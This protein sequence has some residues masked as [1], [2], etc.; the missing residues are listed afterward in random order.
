MTALNDDALAELEL[1]AQNQKKLNQLTSRMTGI[2]SEFDRRLAGLEGTLLPIHHRTQTL[3]RVEKNI[4]TTLEA[5]RHTLGHFDVVEEEEPK[6]QQGPD[7]RNLGPYFDTM[8]RLVRGLEYLKR[9]DLKS[10]EGVMRRMHDLI[11]TGARNLTSLLNDWV[12]AESVAINPEDYIPRRL[13]LPILS[14]ATLEAIIPI[15]SYLKGLPTN[16]SNGYAPFLAALAVYSDTRGAYM[17]QS[18]AAMGNALV[19]FCRDRVAAPSNRGAMTAA[20]AAEDDDEGYQRGSAGAREW[21]KAILDMAE[22]DNAILT[23]LLRGISPP[24]SSAT[25]ASTFSR[26]LRPVLRHFTA[27]MGSLH[28]HVRRHISSHTLFAFDLIGALSDLQSRWHT[29]IV[30]ASGKDDHDGNANA[31]ATGEADAFALAQQLQSLRSSTM[32]V[33]IG[34][35]SD[36]QNIPRQREGE[37]P[38]TTINELTYLGLTFLRQMCEYADVVTSLLSTLGAGNWMMAGSV[39]PVLSMPINAEEQSGI[40]SQYLCDALS[41]VIE[42]LKARSRAIKQPSTASIFLLNNIGRLQRD[43]SSSSTLQECLG[44]VAGELLTHAMRETRTAYMD[45]WG[46]VVSA[47]MEEG[48]SLSSSSK[49]ASSKLGAGVLGGGDRAQKEDAKQRF[50]R[51]FE[52]LEDLE[53]LHLAYPL[54]REDAELRDNLRRDVVKMVMPLYRRFVSRQ[55]AANFSSNPHKHLRPDGEVEERLARL[56]T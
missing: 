37:V 31:G 2:L 27:V 26:L 40:L 12:S 18:V 34:F 16:P 24:S 29:V 30:K 14:G 10:Q 4:D 1:L 15:F 47:L 33:F 8:D 49:T 32:N 5:L 39:A 25:I 54:S 7:V 9:S 55:M 6:I 38:S 3:H 46:S 41:T 36:V 35:L 42:A 52:G 43:I 17:E 28:N 13:P 50:A 23:N 19:D 11:E 48:G 51:F 22:N 56:Y 53:R 44:P 21:V 20:F 45:A